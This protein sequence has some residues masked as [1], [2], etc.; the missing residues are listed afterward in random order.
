[1]ISKTESINF[2]KMRKVYFLLTM[3][4]MLMTSMLA[5]AQYKVDVTSDP[6]DN[7]YSGSQ[8]FSPSEIATALNTD[9]ETLAA[10]INAGGNVYIKTAGGM[11]NEYTGNQNEFWM[12]ASG[13][14]Q[15]YGA[16]GSCWFAGLYYNEL[17]DSTNESAEIRINVG[18]MPKFFSKVYENSELT[19]TLILVSGDKQV[20][21]DVALKVNAAQ[22]PTLGP[23]TNKFSEL[24]I[25]KSYEL[26]LKYNEGMSYENIESSISI[27]GIADALGVNDAELEASLSNMI[28][29]RTVDTDEA[30]SNSFSDILIAAPFET[31]GWFGRYSSYDESTG[32]EAVYQQNGP[33]GWGAN[34]TF[35]LQNMKIQDGVFTV[36]NG[37]YPSTLA[38]GATDYAEI[39]IINGTKAAKITVKVEVEAK[40]VYPADEMLVV[41]NASV[42]LVCEV[43]DNYTDKFVTFDIDDIISKLG[44]SSVDD[45]IQYQY[46]DE[47]SF[48]DVVPF[49]YWLNEQ[50][51]AQQWGSSACAQLTPAAL[52]EGKFC[53]RQMAGVYDEI[54]EQVGPF[55]LK[56]AL[57]YEKNLYKLTINYFVKPVEKHGEDFVYT[58][59]GNDAIIKQF[60]PNSVGYNGVEKTELDLEYIEKLI[61]TRDFKLYADAHS[62]DSLTNETTLKWSDK[63][64]CTPAPGFW[65]GSETYENEDNQT[66]VDAVNWGAYCSF[67]MTYNDGVITWYEYPES[68]SVGESFSANIYLVNETTGDYVKYLINVSYVDQVEEEPTVVCT[69]EDKVA[70]SDFVYDEE[71]YIVA[72]ISTGEIC[73]KLGIT[74]EQLELTKLNVA[75][76]A[77]MF[78]SVEYG[79]EVIFDVNGYNVDEN[80]E[81]AIS[82]TAK[83]I[84]DGGLKIV[85]DAFKA[86]FNNESQEPIYARFAIKYENQLARIIVKMERPLSIIG[87]NDLNDGY[88]GGQGA[89][90]TVN[91]GQT[92]V[93]EFVNY[94]KGEAN[95]QNFV[96][97]VRNAAENKDIVCLR[98]DNWENISWSNEG[99]VSDYNWDTFT[100][101][102][103]GAHVS[104]KASFENATLTVSAIIT[105]AEGKTYNYS[106]TKSGIEGSYVKTGLTEE[107]ACLVVSKADVEG[108]E[109][110]VTAIAGVATNSNTMSVKKVV[111]NGKLTIVKGAAEY[112]VSGARVK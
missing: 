8:V 10:A 57:A 102:M 46:Q 95:Y 42:D 91:N 19:C 76:T 100:S 37:Q 30:G 20:S 67:G 1:M 86:D 84:I 6:E 104:L 59:K 26:T 94:T 2:I 40:E 22:M 64:T 49:D 103:K 29:T 5:R 14:S 66:V 101:D 17:N 110:D 72:S 80:N 96:L 73:E 90:L 51:Y 83:I 11:S 107:A 36:S 54:T 7:Y 15:A 60:V 28:F 78:T 25:V 75:K 35:Y 32:E 61:G 58:K 69:L 44:C 23:S 38:A 98:A 81:D 16:E 52:A 34:C 87:K 112:S 74:V 68:R 71:G 99:C 53:V 4:V 33:K 27:E 105:T 82:H 9:V 88:Y 65:F 62:T 3:F 18:Q 50:G 12:N 63:Y 48:A 109:V 41:G 24:E 13:V 43:D 79:N 77:N 97:Y 39:Y 55:P 45:I 108:E 92:A 56:Y 70:V 47:N 31:D 21:F 106:Y 93:Y 85:V 89:E 111:R